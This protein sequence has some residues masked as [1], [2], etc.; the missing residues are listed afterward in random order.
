MFPQVGECYRGENGQVRK[1]LS[2]VDGVVSFVLVDDSGHMP[3][4][5]AMIFRD[6]TKK[7]ATW[8]IDKLE[9]KE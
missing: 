6:R 3:P 5:G 1:V 4:R 2:I 8:A 7:F 9:A